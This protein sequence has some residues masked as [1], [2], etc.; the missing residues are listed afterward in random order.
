MSPRAPSPAKA[1]STVD[2]RAAADAIDAF[3]R[4]IGR[5]EPELVGTGARVTDM[6]VED[7]CSGYEVDTRKLVEGSVIA[8]SAPN[9]VVVRDIHVVTTCP[10]HL[11][12]GLGTATVAFKA[13][14]RLVG[15]GTVA[16]LVSAHAQRLVLQEHIGDAVVDD[17]DAVLAPEWV[18]CRL[19]LAH[20]CMI[21]RGER[22]IGSRVETVALRGPHDRVAEAHRALGV[23][24]GGVV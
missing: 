2:R 12:P 14:T 4:A 13:T 16:A 7:L 15:L 20:T 22:A 21:A 23:G 19:L 5:N 6:F 11:V 24:R 17:L 3:L 18:G 10:H 1:H 9:L 8:A